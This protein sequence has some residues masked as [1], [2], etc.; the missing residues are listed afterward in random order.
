[1]NSTSAFQKRLSLFDNNPHK[2]TVV[3]KYYLVHTISTVQLRVL[4]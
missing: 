2:I 1:M 4:L 3:F